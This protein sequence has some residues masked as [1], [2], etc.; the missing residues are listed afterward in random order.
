MADGRYNITA[1]MTSSGGTLL[2]STQLLPNSSQGPLVIDT[3]SPT[4]AGVTL[5]PATGT[6]SITYNA[7]L[8]GIDPSSMNDAANFTLLGVGKGRRSF[9][10]TGITVDAAASNGQVTE[11]VTFNMPSRV[12]AGTY[13]LTINANGLTDNAGNV[14]VEKTYVTFPQ[15]TNAPNPNYVAAFRVAS[16]GQ[17]AGPSVYVSKAEQMAAA[18][19]VNRVSGGLSARSV[20]FRGSTRHKHG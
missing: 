10:V 16:N 13:V 17:V 18:K 9:S 5:D 15:T 8:S 11:H 14:L 12:V 7:D 1:T 2:E 6:F 4:I 19:Y 20:R 3:V